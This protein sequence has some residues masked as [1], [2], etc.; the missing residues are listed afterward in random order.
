VAKVYLET[1]FISQCVTIRA[2]MIDVVR[3][4]A[5]RNWLRKYAKS[6][7]LCISPEVVRELSSEHFPPAVRVAALAM[8][9]GLEALAVNEDVR[10]VADL[11]V[12]ERVM[13][14]PAIEGDAVHLAT[15]VVHRV[16][17]L[18]TWNQKHLANPNKRTH[19]AVICARLNLPLPQ[20][21]TPDL[22]IVEDD[23]E[24]QI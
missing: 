8:L 6:F 18:M 10:A 4:E 24:Q 9:E 12:R 1:S 2:G 22:M 7:E 14:G 13:P 15:C 16:D 23:H 11:L 17:Y 20:V 19:L 5:S 21:V 3:R